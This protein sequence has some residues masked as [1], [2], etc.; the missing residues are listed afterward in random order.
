MM[1]R[2]QVAAATRSASREAVKTIGA[3]R[4]AA[5]AGAGWSAM[6][7][8]TFCQSSFGEVGG[9]TS[10]ALTAMLVPSAARYKPGHK[11][12]GQ[13]FGSPGASMGFHVGSGAAVV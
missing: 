6:R 13:F 11:P 3:K 5:V 8:K 10:G 1:R 2:R 12:G 4:C 9:I 7:A